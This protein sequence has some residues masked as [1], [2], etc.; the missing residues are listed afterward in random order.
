MRS[1]MLTIEPHL[2]N[3]LSIDMTLE[4]SHDLKLYKFRKYVQPE[5][6]AVKSVTLDVSKSNMSMSTNS[7]Q[8]WNIA[9][10]VV[11]LE[12]LLLKN[13][14]RFNLVRL[15]NIEAIE[16]TSDMSQLQNSTV[17]SERQFV[18][19][20]CN[21]R[22]PLNVQFTNDTLRIRMRENTKL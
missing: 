15:L 16:C 14:T 2:L 7:V 3:M 17:S 8:F 21:V 19:M 13:F 1:L 11:K 12:V 6:V 22:T 18:N 20:N 4:T 10:M 5:N 9:L